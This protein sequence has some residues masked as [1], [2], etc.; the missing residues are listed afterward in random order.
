MAK[1]LA[2]AQGA[3]LRFPHVAALCEALNV[4]ACTLEGVADCLSDEVLNHHQRGTCSRWTYM[5]PAGIEK[6]LG[7][8]KPLPQEAAFRLGVDQ[9]PKRGRPAIVVPW[10][11]HADSYWQAWASFHAAIKAARE[12]AAEAAA[13]LDG[14]DARHTERP[15]VK[16]LQEIGAAER[17]CRLWVWF[18]WNPYRFPVESVA[19]MMGAAAALHKRR[20]ELVEVAAEMRTDGAAKVLASPKTARRKRAVTLRPLTPIQRQTVQVVASNR[21]NFRA[22]AREMGKNEKTV[23]GNWDAAQ[24]KLTE[25]GYRGSSVRAVPLPTDGREQG[26]T[27]RDRR[28]G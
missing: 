25:I 10:V 17:A 22:A 4:A 18:G 8:R 6:M 20:E 14:T 28:L 19:R 11:L 1:S 9:P 16:L 3:A 23:R 27:G 7:F 12:R 24:R 13:E 26:T 21:G 5:P 15:S 2:K